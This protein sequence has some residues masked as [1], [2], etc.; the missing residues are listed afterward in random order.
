MTISLFLLPHFSFSFYLY[1]Y[2]YHNNNHKHRDFYIVSKHAY[3][4]VG[5][6]SHILLYALYHSLSLYVRTLYHHHTNINTLL[7]ARN[8]GVEP[9]LCDRQSHVIT[10]TLIPHLEQVEGIEPSQSVWKT[11]VLPLNHTCN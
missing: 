10:T 1:K 11:D 8:R 6:L 2:V 3:N 4:M 5:F 9:L 7:L